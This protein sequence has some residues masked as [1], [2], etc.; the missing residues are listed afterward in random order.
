MLLFG[1]I[2]ADHHRPLLFFYL[3]PARSTSRTPEHSAAEQQQRPQR[4]KKDSQTT[5]KSPKDS[6]TECWPHR[7]GKGVLY[8]AAVMVSCTVRVG[9]FWGLWGCWG[10]GPRCLC[11]AFA[12]SLVSP[13]GGIG[14]PPGVLFS[15][16]ACLLVLIKLWRDIPLT[17]LSGKLYRR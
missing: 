13:G 3:S 17:G 15:P 5:Q 2:W 4:P 10:E 11:G 9:R 16:F 7:N 1:P 6:Q 14:R 8:L 12:V